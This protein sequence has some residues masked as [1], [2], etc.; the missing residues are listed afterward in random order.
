[1]THQIA[2]S[3]LGSHGEYLPAPSAGLRDVAQPYNAVAN[4]REHRQHTAAHERARAG[5]RRLGAAP[6]RSRAAAPRPPSKAPGVGNTQARVNLVD[7]AR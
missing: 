5:R 2:A 6:A 1:M 4:G 3:R 7:M